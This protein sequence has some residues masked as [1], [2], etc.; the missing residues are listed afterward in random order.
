MGEVVA[1]L[2]AG[3]NT[4]RLLVAEQG[5]DGR[6]VEL[7]RQLRFV[8]L[9]Q[10]VDA[11]RRFSPEAIG[12]A[13]AAVDE[14]VS[15][16]NRL[17]VR[18]A[19]FVA[20]SASRDAAN[21]GEFFAGV[22]AR[23]GIVPELIS[24]DEEA[25]LSFRGAL[26]G[27]RIDGEPVLVMDSGGGSTELV[28]GSASGT[29][30]AAESL[31]VGSRRLRERYL[32]SDPP[33]PGQVAEARAEVRR[34]LDRLD[35]DLG[36]IAT[37]VGVAGTVTTMAAVNLGL[38]RYDRTRVHGCS[39]SVDEVVALADRLLAMRVD[40]VVALGPVQPE[41]AKVLCAGALVVAE[42]AGRVGVDLQASEADIL[43]GIVLSILRDGKGK[44]LPG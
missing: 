16:V 4:L 40:E 41:R 24:G 11:T 21:R 8:G 33:A 35:V 22:T 14:Y 10:G 37:F 39:M 19:R 25:A 36:G 13:W 31:D 1:G 32:L 3:T 34:L 43:D 5:P 12:R 9:G 28:R 7:D 17:G 6:M 44:R 38:T 15:V 26:S 23:L 30:E 18:R 2:D 27:A 42:V 20:T 29:I